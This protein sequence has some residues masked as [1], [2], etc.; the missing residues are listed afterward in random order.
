MTLQSFVLGTTFVCIFFF[1]SF[2]GCTH[3]MLK[4]PGQISKLHNGSN[5]G[6]LVIKLD[7]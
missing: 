1:F 4:F 2:F 7:P 3:D 5:Q 6:C